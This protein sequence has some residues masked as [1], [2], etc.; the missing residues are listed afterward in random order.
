M[1]FRTLLF[2]NFWLKLVSLVIASLIWLMIHD[3]VRNEHD[4]QTG[5]VHK[6]S[7]DP[8]KND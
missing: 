7:H 1:N 5:I 6:S 8:Q 4:L 2:H 3:Q